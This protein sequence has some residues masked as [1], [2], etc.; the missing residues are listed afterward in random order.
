MNKQD[1][2]DAILIGLEKSSNLINRCAI[3]ES[4]YLKDGT[5][6]LITLEETMLQLY[7]A[8]LKYVVQ[9]IKASRSESL[10]NAA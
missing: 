2:A 9:A 7:I 10:Q 4:I 6:A 3:Y 8:V 1:T 5:T